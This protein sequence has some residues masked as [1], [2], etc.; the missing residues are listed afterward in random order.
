EAQEGDVK[1]RGLDIHVLH[2][3]TYADLTG[4]TM[5]LFAEPRD[6]EIYVKDVAII[7]ASKGH[8]RVEYPSIIL[9]PN[10]VYLILAIYKNDAII[11]TKKFKLKVGT[12]FI[13]DSAIE[14]N[15][16]Y[17]LFQRLIEAAELVEN[18]DIAS[19]EERKKNEETRQENEKERQNRI[20]DIE[21]R[22]SKL[23]TEQQQDAEVIDARHS[24]T[25][26]KTFNSL[27]G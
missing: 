6:G 3:N 22:F 25:K 10:I 18:V 17:P 20:A 12:G 5:K 23:T 11:S 15:D 19:E 24:T 27:K 7:D 1:S 13:T 26:D 14:G 21:D 9:Q 8:F 16:A 4:A 2:N